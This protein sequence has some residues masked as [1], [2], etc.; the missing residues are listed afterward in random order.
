[1]WKRRA[2]ATRLAVAV[3]AAALMPAALM[4]AASA[5]AESWLQFGRDARQS[6]VNERESVLSYGSLPGV[7]VAWDADS[8]GSR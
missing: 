3:L 1:M 5:G 6:R 2:I 7:G 8:G 4:P